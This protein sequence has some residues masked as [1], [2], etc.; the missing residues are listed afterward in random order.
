[1]DQM[2]ASTGGLD[3]NVI[4]AAAV[5]LATVVAVASAT[6]GGGG[7]GIAVGSGVGGSSRRRSRAQ[8]N[9]LAIPYDAPARLAYQSWLDEHP[10]EKWNEPAYTAFASAYH[11]LAVAEARQKKLARDL[12]TFANK[13]WPEPA[14]RPAPRVK[15]VPEGETK[16]SRGGLF[17]ATS[18]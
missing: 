10:D 8:A 6:S 2:S 3:T 16:T 15:I 7:D 17:F 14:P 11:E 4:I 5:G 9:V 18:D 1:M 13:P 12:A